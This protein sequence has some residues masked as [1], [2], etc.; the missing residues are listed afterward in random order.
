M[1][2]DWSCRTGVCHRCES[3]LVSGAVTYEPEPLDDPAQGQVAPPR[4]PARRVRA[5]PS[6]RR[7]GHPARKSVSRRPWF[8]PQVSSAWRIS[9]ASVRRAPRR[10]GMVVSTSTTSTVTGTTASSCQSGGPVTPSSRPTEGGEQPGA[11][12]DAEDGAADG[13][14]HLG[15]RE[16]RADLLGRGTESVSQGR[17]VPAVERGRP[18]DE[19]GVDGVDGGQGGQRDH[20]DQQHLVL[21]DR[22]GIGPSDE[23]GV[24]VVHRT[25]SPRGD[26]PRDGHEDADRAQHDP[27]RRPR[28]ARVTAG[29]ATPSAVAAPPHRAAARRREGERR[30]SRRRRGGRHR[31]R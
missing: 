12:G 2:A 11:P 4:A 8:R 16:S 29:P 10:A 18:G 30:R 31:G 21:S 26:D 24:L 17:G 22:L 28:R 27:A 6:T 7:P 20:D 25:G 19:D 13:G 5:S 1:P 15:S 14:Q 9:V 3:G 23:L